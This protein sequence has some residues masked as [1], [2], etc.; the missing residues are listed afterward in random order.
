M[1]SSAVFDVS[2]DRRRRVMHLLQTASPGTP[3][4]LVREIESNMHGLAVDEEHY[5]D[6]ALKVAQNIR[7][8][9]TKAC[10][11]ICHMSTDTL[12]VG[13]LVE[14]I[15]HMEDERRKLFQTMLQEKYDSISKT[16]ADTPSSLRCRRCGSVELMVE[17]KQT[18]SADEGM[19]VYC[20]CGTCNNR[21][22]MR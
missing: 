17:Q 22:T 11:D 4:S 12:M 19:S 21:W 1:L 10:V 18:R 5:N 7:V 3:F 20:V 15:H 13:T 16:S 8:D 2:T 6:L 9:S 14:K